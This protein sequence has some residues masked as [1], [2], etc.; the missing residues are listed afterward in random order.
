MSK[1]LKS[2]SVLV[3]ASSSIS[4]LTLLS[5]LLQ[6]LHSFLFPSKTLKNSKH[7]SFLTATGTNVPF[8][9]GSLVG[10]STK[11]KSR[12]L[13]FKA[14]IDSAVLLQLSEHFGRYVRLHSSSSFLKKNQTTKML[15][16]ISHSIFY[17][18]ILLCF[19]SPQLFFVFH[20][21]CCYILK[22]IFQM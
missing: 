15:S 20:K 22:K 21:M 19:W 5:S 10:N 6:I 8:T 16:S 13:S 18:L 14:L 12:Q 11:E 1:F 4:F 9:V 17:F 3:P 2:G 7:C